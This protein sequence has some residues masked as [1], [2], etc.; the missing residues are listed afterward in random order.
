MGPGRCNIPSEGLQKTQ[1]PSQGG[2]KTFGGIRQHTYISSLSGFVDGRTFGIDGIIGCF[3][4]WLSPHAFHDIE[5]Y[6]VGNA[7]ERG[8][9]G[10]LYR[11]HVLDMMEDHL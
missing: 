4:S 2:A 3:S 8:L 6:R 7:L 10:P 11:H 9:K 1:L 5:R